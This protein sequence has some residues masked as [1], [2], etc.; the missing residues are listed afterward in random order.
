MQR[1]LLLLV[2]A[3]LGIFPLLVAEVR[4][5]ANISPQSLPVASPD[6]VTHKDAIIRQFSGVLT[7]MERRLFADAEDGRL[8]VFSPLDAAL[9]ASGEDR[10]ERLR[11]YEDRLAALV[12]ELRPSIEADAP[13]EKNA[14]RAF[15]FLHRRV[16]FGGYRL[17]CT[18]LRMAF[19]EGRYNCVSATVLFNGLA[20]GVGLNCR[21]LE[22]PGHAAS[23]VFLPQGVLDLETTCPRW[24]QLMHD[25]AKQ[26]EA[27]TE[28][29][30]R[31]SKYD[32]SEIREVTPIQMA[33]MIYYNRGVDFLAEKRF[34]EAAAVNAKALRLDPQNATAKGNFLATLNNWSIDLGNSLHY[35]AAVE[36]LRTGKEIDQK[37]PPFRRN[38]VY[39]YHKW[40]EQLCS[41]GKFSE[42]IDLLRQAAAE[43][44]DKE[45]FGRSI[46]IVYRL[47]TL[48]ERGNAERARKD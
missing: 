30:G 4:A 7:D 20:Q 23:R 6:A 33:A 21:G 22:A 38:F 18:D 25:P 45:E 36:L 12:A 14:E 9:I 15:D 27:A 17:E 28:T 3:A 47:W 2:L 24:F 16:L 1:V 44:P 26:A 19:D 41:G 43:L 32:R 48:S 10:P 13:M 39:L 37:Y 34:V 40:S 31:L 5:A 35:A 46:E 11:H 8:D 42:A 29:P